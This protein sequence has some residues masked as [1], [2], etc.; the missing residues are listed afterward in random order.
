MEWTSNAPSCI[1]T[2]AKRCRRPAQRGPALAI[3]CISRRAPNSVQISGHV[4][5]AA[6]PAAV[7]Y[8]LCVP[9]AGCRSPAPATSAPAPS[10]TT[11][12]VAPPPVEVLWACG[13]WH[14]SPVPDRNQV[15]LMDILFNAPR[16]DEPVKQLAT[17][18][19]SDRLERAG[20]L[21]L[22]QYPFGAVRAKMVVADFE[23]ISG[24]VNLA[25]IVRDTTRYSWG[26]IIEY[27]DVPTADDERV[28]RELGRRDIRRLEAVRMVTA[29]L[30]DTALIAVRKRPGVSRVETSYMLCLRGASAI[31]VAPPAA[32]R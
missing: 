31:D 10:A 13:G 23:R 20:G 9:F 30:P 8:S 15:V 28:V 4:K 2:V 29:D 6:L 11:A 7:V 17:V 27:R 14:G 5:L 12:S 25:R 19:P 22:H 1:V 18:A 24:G 16:P 26:V 32:M 3:H 21:V